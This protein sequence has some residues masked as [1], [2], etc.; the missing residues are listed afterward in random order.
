VLLALSRS[1]RIA[2]V[3][4]N[5]HLASAGRNTMAIY[6]IHNL[7]Y[8]TIGGLI[9]SDSAFVATFLA[10]FVISWAVIVLLS[11]PVTSLLNG[12]NR[13]CGGIIDKVFSLTDTT[14]KKGAI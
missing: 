12:A 6:L 2:Q 9:V 10:A 3:L 13:F 4:N 8:E 11:Y 5:K 7:L 14:D 1:T